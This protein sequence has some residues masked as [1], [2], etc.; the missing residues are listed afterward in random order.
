MQ[1]YCAP[2]QQP[3]QFAA[4]ELLYSRITV[5]L[6]QMC[7]QR[8]WNM[9]MPGTKPVSGTCRTLTTEEAFHNCMTMLTGTSEV[10]VICHVESGKH[11]AKCMAGQSASSVVD[12]AGPWSSAVLLHEGVRLSLWIPERSRTVCTSGP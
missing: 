8:V 5:W 10:E 11:V 3:W 6:K 9:S 7:V 1:C 4:P 2:A 12:R